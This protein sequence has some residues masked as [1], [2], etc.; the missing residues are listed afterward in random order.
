ML[1]APPGSVP[2]NEGPGIYL[3]FVGTNTTISMRGNSISCNA[4]K[5]IKM[6]IN[7]NESIAPPSGAVSSTNNIVSAPAG[8]VTSGQIVDVYL[9]SKSSPAACD[10]E[11]E[12]YVGT[13][14]GLANYV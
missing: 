3:G 11:G 4:G 14:T 13:T 7:Q 8:S 9:N 12:I 10:C 1:A 5:G 6:E 2:A